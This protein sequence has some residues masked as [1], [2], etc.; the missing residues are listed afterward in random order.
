MNVI[1][2]GGSGRSMVSR[3]MDEA[4]L[5]EI[6]GACRL[7]CPSSFNGFSVVPFLG[8]NLT[9]FQAGALPQQSG[10]QGRGTGYA[11]NIDQLREYIKIHRNKIKVS[12]REVQVPEGKRANE[13]E[14]GNDEE[15]KNTLEAAVCV[16]V[17]GFT[18]VAAPLQIER[19]SNG[20]R[21]ITR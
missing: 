16:C 2:H 4:E 21:G 14:R 1:G 18:R 7:S 13:S 19:C 17:T 3:R 12:G 10:K 20:R 8:R 6:C 11:H 5:A 15:G 9:P